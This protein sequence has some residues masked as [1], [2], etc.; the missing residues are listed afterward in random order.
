MTSVPVISPMEILG[1]LALA[2]VLGGFIGLER[3]HHQRP[4]GLRTHILVSMGSALVMLLSV[5]AFAGFKGVA[6]LN[7]D[8][9]RLAAQVVSGI[10]FLGAGTILRE[11]ANIRG[12]TTAASL[13]VVAG[14]GLA[15]GSGFWVGALATTALAVLT[16]V[17]LRMVE[18][19]FMLKQQQVLTVQIMDRPGQLGAIGSVLGKHAVNIS[20]VDI[21]E[22]ENDRASI[23]MVV[24][25]PPGVDRFSLLEE[26]NHLEG[27]L[28]AGYD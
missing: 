27:V 6:G 4:A 1:R 14:I 24:N 2:A 28:R 13:W 25:L 16:L 11:G 26:L 7:Y 3:E 9:G 20:R 8:P 18:T 22:A 19:R 12:L 23:E 17:L 21:G 10:G 15:A 5:Y